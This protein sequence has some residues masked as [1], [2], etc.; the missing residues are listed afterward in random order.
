MGIGS[1]NF[2]RGDQSSLPKTLYLCKG[3]EMVLVGY[4]I[5]I[6]VFLSNLTKEL[7]NEL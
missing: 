3:L 2:R 7:Q 6:I 5:K 1:I 4:M